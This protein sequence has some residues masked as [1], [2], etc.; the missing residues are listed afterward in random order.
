MSKFSGSASKL[1]TFETLTKGQRS[2]LKDY[3][4][5]IHP[6]AFNV[7]KD[8]GFREAGHYYQDLMDPE[9]KLNQKMQAPYLRQFEE[10]IVPKVSEG[11]AGADAMDSGAF[12]L[13]M[14]KEAGGLEERL[15]GLTE[16]NQ[17]QGA[18]GAMEYGQI[19]PNLWQGLMNTGMRTSGFDYAYLPG[20]SGMLNPIL[21]ALGKGGAA[22]ALAAI[23]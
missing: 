10:E 2:K 4:Q 6:G 17:L 5:A 8:K 12:N 23:L 19:Q 1:K 20:K 9:S 3:I 11:F 15:A 7:S 13:A 22:A 14:S 18:Q 21:S 16:Q